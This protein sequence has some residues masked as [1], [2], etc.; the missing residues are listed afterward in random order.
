[1][2]PDGKIQSEGTIRLGYFKDS[3]YG[4]G[5]SDGR[6]SCFLNCQS[7]GLTGC[8]YDSEQGECTAHTR[9]LVRRTD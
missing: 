3:D 7:F 5:Y 6:A 8:Q 4:D 2:D 1:M 9:P